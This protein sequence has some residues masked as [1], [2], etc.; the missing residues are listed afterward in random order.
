MIKV[1]VVTVSDK[2]FAGEREDESGRVLK[3]L[4]KELPG[5]VSH[6]EIIPDEKAVI[7]KKLMRCCDQFKPDLILTTG[8]TGF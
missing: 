7:K 3:E 5:E 8:G 4:V 2:G 6:Y 1:A